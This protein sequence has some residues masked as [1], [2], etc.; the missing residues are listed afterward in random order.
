MSA[1]SQAY[2]GGPKDWQEV[3]KNTCVKTHWDPTMV[4]QHVLPTFQKDMVLDP[5]PSTRNCYVY[6]NSSPGDASLPEQPKNN[7]PPIPSYLLGGPHRPQ[8]E[9][10]V[11]L[12]SLAQKPVYPPGGQASINFP[13]TGYEDKVNRESDLLRLDE[14]L[15]LCASKRFHPS[16]GKPP[17]GIATNHIPGAAFGNNTTLSP[18]LT[19]VYT[20]SGCRAQDDEYAWNR[21]ARLFFN[22]TRYDATITSPS[23]LYQPSSHN[24]LVCPITQVPEPNPRTSTPVKTLGSD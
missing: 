16:G 12:P 6:Y 17:P 10:S 13:Y 23:D 19:R 4:V 1:V 7:P 9:S 3:F 21:S 11:G 5:R 18:M 8:E 15:T 24:A 22:P 20:K 2:S 14:D